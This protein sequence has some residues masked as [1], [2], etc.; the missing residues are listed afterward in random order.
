MTSTWPELLWTIMQVATVPFQRLLRRH[1][2]HRHFRRPRLMQCPLHITGSSLPSVLLDL[3]SPR[4]SSHILQPSD[5]GW[6]TLSNTWVRNFKWR[7]CLQ[8][9]WWAGKPVCDALV[10]GKQRQLG[11][12]RSSHQPRSQGANTP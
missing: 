8:R 2:L 5:L 1:H 4:S 3:V 6:E 7:S 10:L 12:G 11:G 9:R